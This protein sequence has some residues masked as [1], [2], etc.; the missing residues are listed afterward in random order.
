MHNSGLGPENWV[1]QLPEFKAWVE[2]PHGFLWLHGIRKFR[3][4]E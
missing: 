3:H 1:L 4:L 2:D